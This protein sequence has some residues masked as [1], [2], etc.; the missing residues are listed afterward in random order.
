MF[1]PS[2]AN[3][4]LGNG[5]WNRVYAD[6]IAPIF[7]GRLA[8]SHLF[9][10]FERRDVKADGLS[11]L[12]GYI[13]SYRVGLEVSLPMEGEASYMSAEK[14][15]NDNFY[16]GTFMEHV[17]SV[18][19][20]L[21]MRPLVV[22]DGGYG[23]DVVVGVD[24]DGNQIVNRSKYTYFASDQAVELVDSFSEPEET[25]FRH[26]KITLFTRHAFGI[27]D[28]RW[29]KKNTIDVDA[30]DTGSSRKLAKELLLRAMD[31]SVKS[32]ED[33]SQDDQYVL[34]KTSRVV[35]ATLYA[36]I[37]YDFFK[38]KERDDLV[39]EYD[40]RLNTTKLPVQQVTR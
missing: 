5:V 28:K 22:R 1:E 15:A 31:K 12:N 33:I 38:E 6:L 30:N 29:V 13:G 9:A 26:S 23:E 21:S 39:K 3:Y 36:N 25:M 17:F 10:R 7:P 37:N 20:R 8:S 19:S 4:E 18:G 32:I 16:A 34:E 14:A 24:D 35:P 40:S 27:F 11:D 2:A